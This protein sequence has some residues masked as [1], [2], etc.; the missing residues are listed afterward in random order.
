MHNL[1]YDFQSVFEAHFRE[2]LK[3]MDE[4]ISING[5]T[6]N[7]LLYADHTIIVFSD[8]I[9]VL[10]NVMN[11]ITETNK[12][13]GLRINTSKTKFMIIINKSDK[14]LRS[15]TNMSITVWDNKRS[16]VRLER[17]KPKVFS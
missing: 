9:E 8:A 5:V 6:L 17:R 11:K 7:N 14:N 3:D 4:S 16:A 13:F 15:L 1:S 12:S 10:Q 2:A